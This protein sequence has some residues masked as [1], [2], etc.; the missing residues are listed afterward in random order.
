MT[1]KIKTEEVRKSTHLTYS[2]K[3]IRKRIF[4]TLNQDSLPQT[5]LVNDCEVSAEIFIEVQRP[6][7]RSDE[8]SEAGLHSQTLEKFRY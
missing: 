5:V 8:T 2:K 7:A 6:V 1:V 4:L 3:D